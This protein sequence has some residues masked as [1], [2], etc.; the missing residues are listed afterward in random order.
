MLPNEVG[1]RFDLLVRSRNIS[2]TDLVYSTDSI[3]GSSF[4]NKLKDMK[5]RWSDVM[6]VVRPSAGTF[7]LLLCLSDSSFADVL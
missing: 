6:H 2:L 7:K 4:L 1:P 3:V 5:A